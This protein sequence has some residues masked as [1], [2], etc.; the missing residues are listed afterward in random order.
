M[1]SSHFAPLWAALLAAVVTLGCDPVDGTDPYALWETYEDSTA[2]YHFR[3][4][5]PPWEKPGAHDADGFRLIVGPGE[6][7]L[8]EVG[9]P[10]DGLTSEMGLAVEIVRGV[11]A[12]S[13]A[14]ADNVAWSK[15]GAE[16]E[17]VKEM[18][19]T[20]GDLGKR[21][22]AAASDRSFT[23]VYFDLEGGD[24]VRLIV[25]GR[26]D[27]DDPDVEMILESLEPRSSRGES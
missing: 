1:R 25:V 4:L 13:A 18:E 21:I 9:L 17:P 6:D 19:N 16:P 12:A 24:S 3:Y 26:E 5:S 10:G 20:A 23:A 2:R 14:S 7:P 11:K 27:V 8:D 22:A 15:H